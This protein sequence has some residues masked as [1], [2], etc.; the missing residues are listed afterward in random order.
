VTTVVFVG[1]LLGTMALGTPIAIALLVCALA[2]MVAAG[3]LRAHDPVAE[4][5]RRGRQLPAAGDP[6]L[7]ASPAS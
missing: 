3:Q 7:H 2:L 4:A 1:S 5:H 6:L